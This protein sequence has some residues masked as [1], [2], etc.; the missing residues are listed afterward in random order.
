MKVKDVIKIA[1]GHIAIVCWEK[2]ADCPPL[3]ESCEDCTFI[4]TECP[5]RKVRM[6][7]FVGNAE[8]VPI[9]LVNRTVKRLMAFHEGKGRN[10]KAFLQI[11]V[12]ND[13]A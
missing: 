9:K 1:D 10:T 7:L 12:T 5:E 13:Q 11:G 3:I 8:D 2:V 6:E 4:D